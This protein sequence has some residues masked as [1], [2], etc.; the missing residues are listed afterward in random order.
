MDIKAKPK[1]RQP[2]SNISGSPKKG[3]GG[4]KYSW[5]KGGLDDL[6]AVSIKD[7][8]DPNYDSEEETNEEVVIAKT[9][10]VSPIEV[11]IQDFLSSGDVDETIKAIKE[12][13]IDNTIH[14]QFVKKSII[15]AMEKQAYERELVSKLLSAVYNVAVTPDKIAEGFQAA[16]NSLEDIVLDNPD[17]VDMLSKF[18]A[19]A[20][21]DEVIAP[22]FLK[23]AVSASPLAEQCLVD[24]KGL[25][26]QPFRSERL[27]HIWG[28]GD[29]S[30][31]KRLKG[32]IDMMYE[33]FLNTGDFHEA[34]RTVRELNA[35]F[36]HPQLVKQGIV[37]ALQKDGENRKKILSLIQALSKEDLVS[38]EHVNQGFALCYKGLE[39]LKL[40]LPNAP[41][42]LKELVQSAK[43]L[44]V[45]D[46]DFQE[47]TKA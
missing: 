24:A 5:G 43:E 41:A 10:I 7:E 15:R 16:L 2:S 20:V 14:A 4:G 29:L 13:K 31:V 44:G 32:E 35:R 18:I 19:R 11:L 47:P 3:G 26:N 33:E 34:D 25:L 22:V 36:F 27:A 17:A 45:L 28:A 21:F 23:N 30:S 40:D 42:H 1:D 38:K 39:D 46:T 37:L 8:H 9:E 6:K 12:L